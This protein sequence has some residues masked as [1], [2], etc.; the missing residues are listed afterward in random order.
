LEKLKDRCEMGGFTRL[1]HSGQADDLMDEVPT[2]LADPLPDSVVEHSWYPVLNRPYA[3]MQWVEKANIKEKYVLMSEP[4]HIMLRPLPNFMRHDHPAAFP[5]F[6][7]EP[8]K[9]E[10]LPLVAKHLGVPSITKQEAAAIAPIG[11]SP[12]FLTMDQMKKAMPLW[13]NMSVAIF[14]D[15][16]TNSVRMAESFFWEGGGER[17]GAQW[18]FFL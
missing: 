9:E 7:I 6:Y 15:H 1:L 10:Y 3:F 17:V 4:D 13:H 5:F 14:K 8:T 12:T 11:N 16:D 2:F 18:S